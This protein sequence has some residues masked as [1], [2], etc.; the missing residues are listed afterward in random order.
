MRQSW[1]ESECGIVC[2]R[3]VWVWL[4]RRPGLF[5]VGSYWTRCTRDAKPGPQARFKESLGMFFE[6]VAVQARDRHA[7]VIPDLD[8]YIS[9]SSAPDAHGALRH[10]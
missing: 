3:A 5:V 8:S 2:Y 6:A 9:V 4:T 1:R 10:D 7:G